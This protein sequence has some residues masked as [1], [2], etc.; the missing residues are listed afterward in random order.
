M[1]YKEFERQSNRALLEGNGDSL[2]RLLFK[3]VRCPGCKSVVRP[4]VGW[5]GP[6]RAPFIR[7]PKCEAL[8]TLITEI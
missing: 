8:W 7:C 4:Q 6:K 3:N 1:G 2:E 5:M